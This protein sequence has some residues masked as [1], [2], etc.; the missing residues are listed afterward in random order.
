MARKEQTRIQIIKFFMPV[1]VYI[2][3]FVGILVGLK[4][5]IK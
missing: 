1:V 3:F 5:L 2:Y 4:F